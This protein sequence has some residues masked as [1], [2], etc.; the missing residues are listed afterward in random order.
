LFIISITAQRQGTRTGVHAKYWPG[1]VHQ[2]FQRV[3]FG[4]NM[5]C[6]CVRFFG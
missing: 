6:Q 2:Q 5:F 4:L 3:V 1:D